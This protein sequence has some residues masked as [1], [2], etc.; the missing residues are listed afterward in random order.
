MLEGVDA[1]LL[2]HAF[3]LV[4]HLLAP[5]CDGHVEG[6]IAVGA[7]RFVVPHLQRIMQTLPGRRQSEIHNHRGAARQRRPR[8]A[9]EI[10]GGIG[11]HK[12]HFQMRMR[13]DPARH[14][15]AAR[16]IQLFVARQVRPDLDDL[17]AV[18]QDI[19]LIGQISGDDGSV[20]DDFGHGFLPVF[21]RSGLAL[22]LV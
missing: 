3:H 21:T 18:D 13:V 4:E 6:I 9:F 15:I 7:A 12:R 2:D 8:A 16:R 11:A 14:D 20:F 10:I 19:R 1:A 17:A 5:P 22:E